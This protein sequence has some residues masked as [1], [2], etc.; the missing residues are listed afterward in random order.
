MFGIGVINFFGDFGG[1]NQ[2]G[3]DYFLKDLDFFFI[4]FGGLFGFCYCFYFYY[5][6]LMIFNIGMV[7]GLDVKIE[8]LI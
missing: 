7:R 3:I 6:I 4:G 2:V 8:D 1:V 5:V